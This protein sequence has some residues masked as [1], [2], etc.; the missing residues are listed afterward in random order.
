MAAEDGLL[1]EQDLVRDTLLTMLEDPGLQC[2]DKTALA[3]SLLQCSLLSN[4]ALFQLAGGQ[5]VVSAMCSAKLRAACE[6][7]YA[8]AQM[9]LEAVEPWERCLHMLPV[10]ASVPPAD[11]WPS[12][13]EESEESSDEACEAQEDEESSDEACEAQE[14]EE[15]SD[16]ACEAQEDEE[17]SDEACEAQEDEEGSEEACEAQ[18]DEESSQEDF[19]AQ[20]M[21][22]DRTSMPQAIHQLL[23]V[24]EGLYDKALL[25]SDEADDA[26]QQLLGLCASSAAPLTH[27]A[28]SVEGGLLGFNIVVTAIEEMLECGDLPL[29]VKEELVRTLLGCDALS[30]SHVFCSDGGVKVVSAILSCYAA[31][32]TSELMSKAA[33]QLYKWAELVRPRP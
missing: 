22:H 3:A 20:W 18:E 5:Q 14:D 11:V 15:G 17:S 21:S 16:E 1:L 24:W 9:M 6:A 23:D 13:V 33:F 29:P 12:Y 2:E 31:N 32:K 19:E 8:R 26:L 30:F 27:A 25:F 10:L 7:L 28:M 4:V